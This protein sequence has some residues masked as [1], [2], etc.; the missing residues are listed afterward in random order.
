MPRNAICL[1]CGGRDP[2]AIKIIG[3]DKNTIL[4]ICRYCYTVFDCQEKNPIEH[5]IRCDIIPNFL[6][7]CRCK[8]GSDKRNN[9]V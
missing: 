9:K 5:I 7:V 2:T 4:C 6:H 1:D 8:S 3:C